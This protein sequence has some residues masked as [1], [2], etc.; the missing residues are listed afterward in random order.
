MNRI[1]SWPG[2]KY[3]QLNRLLHY[4][5]ENYPDD[6]IVCEPF[7]GTGAFTISFIEN[8]QAPTFI[9]EANAPLRN[10][11]HWLLTETNQL[12]ATMAE[13]RERYAAASED[14]VVFDQ[15]R[16][17]WNAA[18]QRCP[19]AIETAAWLW[20]LV[21]QS[22]NN[23]ARFNST[24]GYNQTWGK[25]R[26][27]PD[28]NKLY[29]SDELHA[30]AQL[31]ANTQAGVFSDCFHC[32][33]AFLELVDDGREAFCFLDPPY[34][35]QTE[36]YDRGCWTEQHVAKLM[37]Y[38]EWLEERGIA[39]IMTEYMGKGEKRHPYEHTLR[40]HYRVIPLPR[41]MDARPN[42]S[43]LE[44]EEVVILGSVIGEPDADYQEKQLELAIL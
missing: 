22:T 8:I 20:C 24:G 17:G 42:G 21:Y 25:G 7:F 37:N 10:W 3:R 38:I 2:S 5:P 44:T 11:W 27:I 14:R 43:H 26:V 16:D 41:G 30:I 6:L 29:G 34:I 12:I 39:W 40:T 15:M 19:N 31:A 32:L 36:T 35:V 33:D 4:I 28:P 9:A 23:L 18:N 1:L 13:F